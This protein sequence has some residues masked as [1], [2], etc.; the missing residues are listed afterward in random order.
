MT[1]MN[2]SQRRAVI[3]YLLN[4]SPTNEKIGDEMREFFKNYMLDYHPDIWFLEVDDLWTE[5]NAIFS[6]N[7]FHMRG[8][9]NGKRTLC[10]LISFNKTNASKRDTSQQDRIEKAMR[11]AVAKDMMDIKSELLKTQTQCAICAGDL[12][13][14]DVG[15]IHIDHTGAREFRDI[16]NDFLARCPDL[17]LD[18]KT[19]DGAAWRLQDNLDKQQWRDYHNSQA[20]IQMVCA[21]CNLRKKKHD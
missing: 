6:H 21:S 11:E 12:D 18:E 7:N 15:N 10:Q 14:Q 4:H 1:K 19:Y 16:K 17:V 8:T 2:F 3:K 9:I 20:E 5:P 13:T